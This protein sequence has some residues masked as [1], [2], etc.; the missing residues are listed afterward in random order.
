MKLIDLLQV[1]EPGERICVR[2]NTS[3]GRMTIKG[4]REEFIE[5]NY[6]DKELNVSSV[7]FS[8]MYEAILIE[9]EEGSKC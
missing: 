9:V 5:N 2:G 4:E 6:F 8:P 1:I 3:H 7:W